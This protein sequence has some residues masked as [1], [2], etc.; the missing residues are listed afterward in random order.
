MTTERN[1]VLEGIEKLPRYEKPRFVPENTDLKLADNIAALFEQ[2]LEREIASAM[3]LEGWVL[4]RS[5]LEARLDQHR[6]V[7]YIRMTCQT[8]NPDFAR[9]Y[10]DFVEKI[11]PLIRQYEDKLNRHYLVLKE[12]YPL[13]PKRYFVHDRDIQSEIELFREKNVPVLTEL[14]TLS[15]EYQTIC[16]SWTVFFNGREQT[17][18]EMSRYLHEPDR[19]LREKSWRAVVERRAKDAD[20]LEELFDKMLVLRQKL[21]QN[22]GCRNFTEYQFRA[23]HRFD[24]SPK[25]CKKY[26]AAILKLVVPLWKKI[27]FQRAQAMAVRKLRPWD[28]E[29]DPQGRPALKPF[30]TVDRL[31]SGVSQ[32]F[33]A[34]HPDLGRQFDDMANQGLL[35]LTNRKGKAPGGYQNTLNDVRLPFIFM[36]AVGVD[37]DVRTLLHEGGHAFH[38]LACRHDP[39]LA[40]RHAPMEFCE[41]ASM[42][43]ELLGGEHLGFFYDAQDQDRSRIMHLE[44]V[45]YIL[46]WVAI[47]DSFQ[48]WIYENPGHT[49]Q[50]RRKAWQKIY[51]QFGG[52]L[53]DWRG[54]ENFEQILWHRQLHIFEVPFY[55]IE[56]GIAQLGALQIWMNSRKNNTD[57]LNDYLRALARGG[58]RV[59]PEL[60]KTAGIKFDFSGATIAPLVKFLSRELQ[61]K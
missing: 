29:A 17:L 57:T 7:L 30:D 53:L 32:I 2:L 26:H 19:D 47:V 20:R 35:D 50:Q 58:A 61:I 48:H 22:A 31:V 8:D 10:L 28:L 9:E 45:I 39:V 24:Y 16:G 36:N 15:Q 44:G 54:L 21:A 25:E 52:G 49:G 14:Q 42:S 60:F 11:Q 18:V 27:L 5:E 4:D 6:S 38:S 13:D 43:M 59:L 23:Y 40:Y 12:R 56:Y 37:D 33:H 41:V 3:D 46:I 1:I 34:I 51:R 55:Y